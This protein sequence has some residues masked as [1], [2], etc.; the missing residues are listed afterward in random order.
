MKIFLRKTV[1][2]IVVLALVS[3][4]SLANLI[5][6]K[7]YA[8]GQ[9]TS[10]SVQLSDSR[11]NPVTA[12]YTALYT[13]AGTT[14]IK[15]INI[16]F[17][18]NADMTGGVPSGMTT[19]GS[20]KGTISGGG[21]TDANWS[22]VNTTNGTLSY[23]YASGS[24]TAASA[25]TIPTTSIT[26]PSGTTFYAQITTYNTIASPC[27]GVVD[28]SNVIALTTVSG[29]T[30]TVTVAPTIAFNVANYGS[31]VNG[32]GDASPV[33]TTNASIP[34]GT[35]AAGATAWGSQTLTV[36]TNGAHGYTLYVRDSQALTNANSDTIRNQA[37]T[38][39]S[40]A[41][42]DASGSQSSFAYTADGAGVTFGSNLWAGVTQ[43][44]VAIATRTS[45]ISADATHVEY[46]VGISNVQPPGAYSTVIA[47]TATPSY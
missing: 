20:A 26:N 5:V 1:S 35:V 37:G 30:A 25:T 45:A 42:F 46:K 19:T 4:S 13:P 43:T 7:A 11:P 2:I 29:V 16:V 18:A 28:Q 41:S 33:T 9:I 36:S 27:T 14:S 32:S 39:G 10:A 8:V 3:V 44:N 38:P 21:L 31:A 22:L 12:T 47:Y 34:F 24:T 40:P 17:A 15:C 6:S 23:Q